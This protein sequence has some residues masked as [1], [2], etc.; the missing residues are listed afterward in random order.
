LRCLK[1]ATCHSLRMRYVQYSLGWN[2]AV[3]NGT[4]PLMPKHFCV[5][6]SP[7]IAV[8][9]LKYSTSQSWECAKKSAS[10]VEVGQ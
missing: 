5:R 9:W 1:Y 10:L 2:R 6:V 4:L 7:R 8:G 3:M